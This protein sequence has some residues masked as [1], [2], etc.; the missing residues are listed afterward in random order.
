MVSGYLIEFTR[1]RVILDSLAE[2]EDAREGAA[3]MQPVRCHAKSVPG[4]ELDATS[5]VAPYMAID[6]GDGSRPRFNVIHHVSV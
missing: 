6:N 5:R 4:T 3:V 1:G 2:R